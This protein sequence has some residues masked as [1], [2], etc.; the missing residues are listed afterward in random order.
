MIHSEVFS[1]HML[2]AQLMP[3]VK[4][5]HAAY[6]HSYKYVGSQLIIFTMQFVIYAVAC[7]ATTYIVM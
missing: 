4:H 6:I 3:G 2:A 5:I 1:Y 7:M